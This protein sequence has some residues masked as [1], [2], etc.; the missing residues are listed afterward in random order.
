MYGVN[1]TIFPVLRVDGTKIDPTE[2]IFDQP[3]GG[4]S[5]IRGK[6]ADHVGNHVVSSPE[7]AVLMASL[8]TKSSY[9]RR[10]QSL[11]NSLRT[12]NYAGAS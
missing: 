9:R 5:C 6:L 10:P 7:G 11:N 1:I 2:D 4:M 8:G 12:H 3:P